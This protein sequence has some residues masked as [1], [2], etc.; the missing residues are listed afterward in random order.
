M[1]VLVKNKWTSFWKRKKKKSASPYLVWR[2]IAGLTICCVLQSLTKFYSLIN[3]I[4]SLAS[5]CL[6]TS[7]S[8]FLSFRVRPR[9]VNS[10]EI[11]SSS[12]KFFFL[13]CPTV[14]HPLILLDR[15]LENLLCLGGICSRFFQMWETSADYS[16]NTAGVN[17]FVKHWSQKRHYMTS[18]FSG[19]EGN[20]N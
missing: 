3:C 7:L 16:V 20:L 13:L 12:V 19:T 5:Y 15:H 10:D 6:L 2:V 17:I 9:C 4:F 11:M 1:Q 18:I 14:S 8:E